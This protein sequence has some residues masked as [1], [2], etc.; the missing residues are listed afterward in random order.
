[1][2]FK[3]KK[4]EDGETITK[5]EIFERA[6]MPTLV[7]TRIVIT[8]EGNHFDEQ[9]WH[10]ISIPI[11]NE[12]FILDSGERINVHRDNYYRAD[13]YKAEKYIDKYLTSAEKIYGKGFG[14]G[15][16]KK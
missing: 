15:K 2:R 10:I 7:R 3:L 14:K 11:N 16:I 12:W 8:E 4:Y 1:M 9:A 5:S 13:K 6:V